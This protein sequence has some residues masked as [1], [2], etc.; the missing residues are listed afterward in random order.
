MMVVGESIIKR[1]I[2]VQKSSPNQQLEPTS[3]LNFAKIYTVHWDVKVVEIGKVVDA[4][5]P[6]LLSYY[7]ISLT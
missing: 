3:R 7:E 5:M 4:S 6:H 2:A 1:P